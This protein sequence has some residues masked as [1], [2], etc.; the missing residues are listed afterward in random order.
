MLSERGV[1]LYEADLR[2]ANLVGA[3]L[4][5]ANLSEAN[6]YEADLHGANL[7]GANLAG[8][9]LYKADLS[10]T[11]LGGT[12]P[13]ALIRWA[14]GAPQL[15]Q[16]N[17]ATADFKQIRAPPKHRCPAPPTRPAPP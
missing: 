4:R 8:T 17:G 11:D 1:N 15:N 10:G 14:R 9:I 6:L 16:G 13:S 12:D 5:E 2:A 7:R 3:I